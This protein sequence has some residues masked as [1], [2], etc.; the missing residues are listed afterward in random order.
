[1]LETMPSIFYVGGYLGMPKLESEELSQL[2]QRLQ[3]AGVTTVLDIVTPSDLNNSEP[4]WAI[5]PHID[6][7][8]PNDDEALLC[9]GL[10]D[11]PDQARA[12]RERGVKT[13][14]V[15]L[16]SSGSIID[17]QEGRWRIGSYPSECVDP[18]GGG[19]AF[20]AGVIRGLREDWPITRCAQLGA[21]VGG[22]C[23]QTIGC[24]DGIYNADKAFEE[25]D[26]SPPPVEPLP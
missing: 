14:I 5:L 2:L 12:L 4:L 16:G 1:M 24:H 8:M 17:G 26:Q 6:L 7:F 10:K 23:V 11:P 19:D 15:T 9:T 20:A 21:I 18:S 13:T 3:S 25:L 22:S